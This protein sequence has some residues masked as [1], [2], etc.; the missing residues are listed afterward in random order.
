MPPLPP[1]LPSTHT[2]KCTHMRTKIGPKEVLILPAFV[3]KFLSKF[4]SFSF[5]A[6]CW[7]VWYHVGLCFHHVWSYARLDLTVSLPNYL[8]SVLGTVKFESFVS[9]FFFSRVSSSYQLIETKSFS[10]TVVL[11]D[12]T[13]YSLMHRYHLFGWAWCLCVQH[14]KW[15]WQREVNANY[16]H[17]CAR[18]QDVNFQTL[19]TI[20]ISAVTT[21]L[22]CWNHYTYLL[23]VEHMFLE[24]TVT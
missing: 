8:S 3:E 12:E 9:Q 20:R 6:Y 17:I 23:V 10:N 11:S 21:T 18:P 16:W 24:I 7:D 4:L 22:L 2:H 14:T 19:V 13:L 15:Q 5:L 1:P